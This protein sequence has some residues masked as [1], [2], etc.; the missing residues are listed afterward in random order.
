MTARITLE[1][2]RA[3][4]A[5]WEEMTAAAPRS[6]LLQSWAYGEA[7]AAAGGWRVRRGVFRRGASALALV[8]ALEK[9]WPGLGGVVRINRGPVLLEEPP[10]EDVRRV[11]LV[12]LRRAFP[13]YRR[14]LVLIAPEVPAV[15]AAVLCD[16]GFRRRGAGAGW[17]SA[18][19]DLGPDEGV[20]R[21]G[22]KGKWRNMLVAAE[23]A[24]LEIAIGHERPALDR[25]LARHGSAMAERGFAGPAPA[26]IE[27]LF[28][29]ADGA[30]VVLTALG[31]GTPVAAVLI[32]RH[33]RAATYLVGWSGPEGRRLRAHNLLLFRALCEMRAQGCTG[34]DLGGIDERAAPGVALF[35][36]G[37]GGIEY[38]LAGEY[39][40]LGGG[41]R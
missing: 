18:W 39:W 38:E 7:K 30:L 17:R 8:Q 4:R 22:L 31:G 27:R 23:R 9:S 3:G 21:A 14:R 24:G 33:G 40:F 15:E 28:E 1:W 12:A 37:L 13:L 2:D 32:A 35:K 11:V 29:A 25:L 20:L 16:L 10:G 36:R 34:F 6:N 41:G 19:I 26:L 5:E